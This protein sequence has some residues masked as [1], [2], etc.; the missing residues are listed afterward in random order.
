MKR[1]WLIVN[2]LTLAACTLLLVMAVVSLFRGDHSTWELVFDIVLA[3]ALGL[4]CLADLVL[5][6]FRS[7]TRYVVIDL[8]MGRAYGPYFNRDEAAHMAH[9]LQP[10]EAIDNPMFSRYVADDLHD[11]ENLR[12]ELRHREEA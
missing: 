3:V 6:R 10:E 1:T 9:R 11:P 5:G 8:R 7:R 2:L 4:W 12:L